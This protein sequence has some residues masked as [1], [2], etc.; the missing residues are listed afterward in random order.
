MFSNSDMFVVLAVHRSAAQK[1]VR[2]ER[3]FCV[4]S[5]VFF[6]GMVLLF[7]VHHEYDT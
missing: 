6:E 3:V 5:D 1:S 7:M 4:M 2:Q